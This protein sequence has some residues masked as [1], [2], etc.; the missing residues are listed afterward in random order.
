[1]VVVRPS[2]AALFRGSSFH[3]GA[4]QGCEGCRRSSRVPQKRV[5]EGRPASAAEES[6]GGGRRGPQGAGRHR[7]GAL[8]AGEERG[9]GAAGTVRGWPRPAP[10]PAGSEPHRGERWAGREVGRSFGGPG[11]RRAARTRWEI[12]L[13]GEAGPGASGRL[14]LRPRWDGLRAAPAPALL[15]APPRIAGPRPVPPAAGG[16]RPGC[17]WGR[18]LPR[19]SRTPAGRF[20]LS[21]AEEKSWRWSFSLRQG[22]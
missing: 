12:E 22:V 11:G 15:P 4:G 6:G 7:R 14:V 10:S 2:P 5:P 3:G 19:A 18:T 21:W 9:S 20:R 1:M 13:R 17:S 16:S 8:V